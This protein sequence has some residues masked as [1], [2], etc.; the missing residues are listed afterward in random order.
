MS[1]NSPLLK[2]TH[3]RMYTQARTH[4][5]LVGKMQTDAFNWAVLVGGNLLFCV[6][7]CLCVGGCVCSHTGYIL[8]S[9]IVFIMLLAK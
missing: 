2:N 3:T 5:R 7:V 6:S 8:S 4:I 1:E 9:K